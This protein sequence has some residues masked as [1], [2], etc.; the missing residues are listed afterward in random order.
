MQKG[1]LQK[2]VL[3]MY[4]ILC[5]STDRPVSAGQQARSSTV[6]ET[7]SP[8]DILNSR[9][10]GPLEKQEKMPSRELNLIVGASP[11]VSGH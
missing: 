9:I 4:S 2:H 5:L 7:A 11:I 6:N 1:V 8:A 10:L 3:Y